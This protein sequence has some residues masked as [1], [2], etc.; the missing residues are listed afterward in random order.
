MTPVSDCLGEAL[1]A[2][3]SL[4]TCILI[5]KSREPDSLDLNLPLPSCKHGQTT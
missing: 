2:F 3:L 4:V 1:R 5:S